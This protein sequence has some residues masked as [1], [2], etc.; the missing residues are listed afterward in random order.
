M[1]N[2]YDTISTAAEAAPGLISQPALAQVR[3]WD[4]RLAGAWKLGGVIS[5][6]L[7]VG[8]RA[9]PCLLPAWHLPVCLQIIL[10]PLFG[11]LDTLPDGDR[12]LLPLMECLTAGGWAGQLRAGST[13]SSSS[14]ITSGSGSDGA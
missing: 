4:L 8:T 14:S 11:K 12:E 6:C 10:P 1:R 2:A 5:R 3:C 7:L 13:S 9:E